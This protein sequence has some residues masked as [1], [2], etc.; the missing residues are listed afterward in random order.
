MLY[1]ISAAQKHPSPGRTARPMQAYVYKSLRKADTY[2]FLSARDDFARLPD[3]VRE[4]LGSLQ[5]V[6]EVELSEQRKLARVDA[7]TVRE[8]LQSRGFH[9]QFPPT[10]ASA[11][12]PDA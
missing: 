11:V 1:V 7:T 3:P 9:I 8:H 6:L 4:Q 2:V 10:L 5:F 12:A